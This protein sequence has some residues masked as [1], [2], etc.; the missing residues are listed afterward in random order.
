MDSVERSAIIFGCASLPDKSR[1][2]EIGDP[3]FE[4]NAEMIR[5]IRWQGKE[6]VRGIFWPVRDLNW[7]TL[8]QE[9]PEA[10]IRTDGSEIAIDLRFSVGGGAQTQAGALTPTSKWK[11]SEAP[12]P[13]RPG[14]RF[15]I[16]SWASRENRFHSSFGRI[17][18]ND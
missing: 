15:C 9:S 7:I 16:R 12:R 1:S 17:T 8:L 6:V 13:I 3:S 14:S 5:A 2:L 18:G 10:E 11:P 4:F